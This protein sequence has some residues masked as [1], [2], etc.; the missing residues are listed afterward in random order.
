[1]DNLKKPL[2]MRAYASKIGVS[3]TTI[4]NA[5]KDGRLNQSVVEIKGTKYIIPEIANRELGRD[6]IHDTGAAD[7][8]TNNDAAESRAVYEKYRAEKMRLQVLQLSGELVN[9]DEVYSNLYSFGIELRTELMTIPDRTI[10]EIMAAK[11][12]TE[13]HS[14]LYKALEASLL[15]LTDIEGREIAKMPQ[16]KEDEDD[17]N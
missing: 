17:G 14:I 2:S 1:M 12:R 9:R 16:L 3:N 8:E 4:S 11:N 6:F 13:A 7:T 15:K 5:I 10:D